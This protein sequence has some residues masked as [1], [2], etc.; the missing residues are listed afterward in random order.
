MSEI[1]NEPTL[2]KFEQHRHVALIGPTGAGKTWRFKSF[3]VDQKFPKYDEFIYVGPSRQLEDVSKCYAG[4]LLLDDGD[5]TSGHMIYIKLENMDAALLYCTASENQSKQKLLFLDDALIVSSKLNKKI[6][7]WIHQ[8]KNYNTTVVISVHEA[9]GSQDEKMV[10]TAC[11]YFV[12]FNLNPAQI[13][14]LVSLPV[15][16]PII[17]QIES[18]DDPH[19]NF[20]IYDKDIKTVFGN[21]YKVFNSVE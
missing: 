9:F 2:T 18:E 17:K 19:K 11:R 1:V 10:R 14:K 8:A 12:G 21:D 15:D 20:F 13:S 6:S 4:K 3:L 16:N 7:S 5:Y